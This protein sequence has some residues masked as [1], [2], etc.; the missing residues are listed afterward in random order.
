MYHDVLINLFGQ[1]LLN[2]FK[3]SFRNH[4]SVSL[5]LNFGEMTE[6]EEDVQSKNNMNF[7]MNLEP[8]QIFSACWHYDVR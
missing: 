1:H 6:V 5:D 7:I 8:I 3:V 4:F 2:V